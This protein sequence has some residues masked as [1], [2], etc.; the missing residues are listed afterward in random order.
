MATA[1]VHPSGGQFGGF[2]PYGNLTTLRYELRTNAAGVVQNSGLG[3][4]LAVDDVVKFEYPLPAGFL[5]EDV[6][7]IV[8]DAFTASATI[9]VGFAYADG[10]DSTEFPQ[11]PTQW[12]STQAISAL[13]RARTA[14]SAALKALPKDAHLTVTLKGAALADAGALQIV[15]HGERLGAV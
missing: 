5:V 12:F 3:S 1:K 9:N 10:Q 11:S 2:T 6:Q 14:S 8:S 7:V 15:V 13:A 4:A